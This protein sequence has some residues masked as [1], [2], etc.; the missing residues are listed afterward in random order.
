[1]ANGGRHLAGRSLQYFVTFFKKSVAEIA[2][3]IGD[4]RW[5]ESLRACKLLKT[6]ILM[7]VA[8]LFSLD[9]RPARP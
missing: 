5:G 2:T 9:N 7:A 8:I 1:M 3:G 6:S 4:T